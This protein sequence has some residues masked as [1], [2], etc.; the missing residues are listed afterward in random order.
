MKG[1]EPGGGIELGPVA[2]ER[3]RVGHDD[4]V[5]LLRNLPVLVARRELL[6]LHSRARGRLELRPY[7]V[8]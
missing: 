6:D 8:Y 2:E 7:K 5:A 1:S 3:A 4:L